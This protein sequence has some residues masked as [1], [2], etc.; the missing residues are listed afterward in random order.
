MQRDNKMHEAS[1]NPHVD[2]KQENIL[3]MTLVFSEE[4]NLRFVLQEI[5]LL[6]MITWM[7]T[8]DWDDYYSAIQGWCVTLYTNILKLSRILCYYPEINSPI[9]N[10]THTLYTFTEDERN[11]DT[12]FSDYSLGNGDIF[13]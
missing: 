11:V 8:L 3:W 1:W 5:C 13:V 4:V 7:V 2:F 12:N 6:E 9:S 10:G